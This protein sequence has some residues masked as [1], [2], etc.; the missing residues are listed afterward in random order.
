MHHTSVEWLAMCT[1]LA[2]CLD[3]CDSVRCGCTKDAEN[4]TMNST[5]QDKASTC[6]DCR[7]YK[8]SHHKNYN[9]CTEYNRMDLHSDYS[10][11]S[12]GRQRTTTHTMGTA[13]TLNTIMTRIVVTISAC[14]LTAMVTMMTTTVKHIYVSQWQWNP[15][16]RI[17]HHSWSMIEYP[18]ARHY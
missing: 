18:H 12:A 8:Y 1:R 17:E 3:I 7:S 10:D 5:R 9:S 2:W 6:K 14:A 16:L 11:Y 13:S 4:S 15:L